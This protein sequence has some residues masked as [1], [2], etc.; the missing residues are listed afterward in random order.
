MKELI[1]SSQ[2]VIA[3]AYLKITNHS[4]EAQS[5]MKNYFAQENYRCFIQN[6]KYVYNESEATQE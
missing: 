6:L 5:V 2:E 1:E 3:T 4:V